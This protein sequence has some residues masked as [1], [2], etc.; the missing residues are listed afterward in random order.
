MKEVN[1][2]CR[3]TM[4]T[5]IETAKLVHHLDGSIMKSK[6]VVSTF[7]SLILIHL[8]APNPLNIVYHQSGKK[9]NNY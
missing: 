2:V 4:N 5:S 8:L 6:K 7:S 3:F 9:E 1:K